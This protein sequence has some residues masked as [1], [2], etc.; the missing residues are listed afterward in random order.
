MRE[1]AG[2][3][4]ILEGGGRKLVFSLLLPPF[5]LT[6]T[7]GH[8]L[9]RLSQTSGLLCRAGFPQPG[10]QPLSGWA[11]PCCSLR[12]PHRST[13]HGGCAHQAAATPRE[14]QGSPGSA[15]RGC[16]SRGSERGPAQGPPSSLVG[17]RALHLSFLSFSS[18]AFALPSSPTPSLSPR[19]CVS[20]VGK[21]DPTRGGLCVS[22]SVLGVCLSSCSPHVSL[23]LYFCLSI[24][25]SLF[26]WAISLCLCLHLS[27][28]LPVSPLLSVSGL[29]PSPTSSPSLGTCVSGPLSLHLSAPPSLSKPSSTRLPRPFI[30][31]SHRIPGSFP[32]AWPGPRR[33]KRL[34]WWAP[35][36][37]LPGPAL[38]LPPRPI[39][40]QSW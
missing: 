12:S 39:Q 13:G 2:E 32:C 26:P 30:D 4:K 25:V 20:R 6:H 14:P 15:L 37:P 22:V 11:G 27:L 17:L 5:C 34:C 29:P 18:A 19:V 38:R 21:V 36:P 3:G 9:A 24:S 23:P 31:A 33:R 7:H 8:T 10:H 1:P 16:G 28:S 40:H 35:S